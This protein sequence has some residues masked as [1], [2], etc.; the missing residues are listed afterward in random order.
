M[1]NQFI[2]Q[3]AED[4]EGIGS[5]E[6]LKRAGG[7]GRYQYVSMVVS[8][9]GLLCDSLYL[10]SIPFFTAPP[11]LLCKN[12]SGFYES[13]P[14]TREYICDNGIHYKYDAPEEYNF[15]TEFDLLC[16]TSANAWLSSVIFIGCVPGFIIFGFLGDI[17]GRI[18]MIWIS[19][20]L[21]VLIM[22]SM[23]LFPLSLN[24]I[25]AATCLIG[26]STTG[27][28]LSPFSLIFEAVPD[29]YVVT[30]GAILNVVFASS[31][32]I[33]AFLSFCQLSWRVDC[34]IIVLVFF[35]L[36]GLTFVLKEPPKYELSKRRLDRAMKS[37]KH[38]A[39]INRAEWNPAWE[40]E[41]PKSIEDERGK[42]TELFTS[43]L[44]LRRHILNVIIITACGMI[45]YGII[46]NSPNVGNSPALNATFN[47]IA[48]IIGYIV[49]GFLIKQFSYFACIAGGITLAGITLLLSD[50]FTTAGL[51]TL[52]GFLMYIGRFG[53][54]ISYGTVIIGSDVLFP[55]RMRNTA[56]STGFG[57][58]AIGEACVA[59][60]I[61]SRYTTMV[62]VCYFVMAVLGLIS[63]FFLYKDPIT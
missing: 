22:A 5:N 51:S 2:V 62:D 1:S 47:A 9:L 32:L 29:S 30:V 3:S 20:A 57:V 42:L 50:L 34:L 36:L 41:A 28:A 4:S 24:M 55:P 12:S 43:S 25:I 17:V 26:F 39:R 37:F 38:I 15:A 31:Q 53:N 46:M 27:L 40:L 52:A 56:Y 16:K 61:G 23:L 6:A 14:Y 58:A 11:A 13:C 7:F 19:I 48:E 49:G 45:Y 59:H 21:N 33:V 44:Y 18:S 54:S 35:L 10:F 63:T 60:M 8:V